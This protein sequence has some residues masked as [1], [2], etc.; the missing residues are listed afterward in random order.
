[1][2]HYTPFCP[3]FLFL[4]LTKLLTRTN[5]SIHVILYYFNDEKRNDKAKLNNR[6]YCYKLIL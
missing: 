3:S 5:S 4:F 6:S 1:M 2:Y